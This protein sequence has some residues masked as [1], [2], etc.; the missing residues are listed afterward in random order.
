MHLLLPVCFKQLA[1]VQKTRNPS[2][3]MRG[4]AKPYPA[5]FTPQA[6]PK[7]KTRSRKTPTP[8]IKLRA[9]LELLR[10]KLNRQEPRLKHYIP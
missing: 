2:K 9:N 8:L 3:T 10:P 7:P 1:D 5:A 6:K 4:S